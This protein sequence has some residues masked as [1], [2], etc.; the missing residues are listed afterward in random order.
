MQKKKKF[1]FVTKFCYFAANLQMGCWCKWTNASC[2]SVLMGGR[3]LKWNIQ[4]DKCLY[5]GQ[6]INCKPTVS[7]VEKKNP[8]ASYT[9]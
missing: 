4:A 8:N 9:I 3:V 1:A 7:W 5:K 2:L 6:I